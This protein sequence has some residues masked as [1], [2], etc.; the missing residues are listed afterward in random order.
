MNI[1]YSK[2]RSISTADMVG[3]FLAPPLT[4]ELLAQPPIELAR[5][6]LIWEA[7]G[8]LDNGLLTDIAAG[9]IVS[10]TNHEGERYQMG[11]TENITALAE[12]TELGI[13]LVKILVR[14]W[15]T[16]VG[17]E[18]L[19]AKKKSPRPSK[20]STSKNGSKTAVAT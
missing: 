5:Q 18:R 4:V 9:L 12:A 16:L 11:S 6:L 13:D 17:M 10:V 19:N 14:G 2:T 3:V 8:Y 1:T 20:A 7:G 15:L